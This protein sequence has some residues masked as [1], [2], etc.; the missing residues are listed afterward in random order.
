ML[1]KSE[2][3]PAL[4]LY[5]KFAISVLILDTD[6]INVAVDFGAFLGMGLIHVS[7]V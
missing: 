2:A 5:L 4:N 6:C 3:E 7:A 1:T